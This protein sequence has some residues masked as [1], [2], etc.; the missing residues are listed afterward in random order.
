MS[1]KYYCNGVDGITYHATAEEAKSKAE[2]ELQFCEDEAPDGWP[3][4]TVWIHWG[5]IIQHV[6]CTKHLTKEECEKE[7]IG[8]NDSWNAYEEYKL[9]DTE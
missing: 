2:E 6:Q 3:D 9:V 8:F 4:E 1:D 7:D 5:R